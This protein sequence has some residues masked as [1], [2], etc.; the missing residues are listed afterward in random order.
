V[1]LDCDADGRVNCR[2]TNRFA[3]VNVY[4]SETTSNGIIFI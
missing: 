4:R 1:A 2:T 3:A